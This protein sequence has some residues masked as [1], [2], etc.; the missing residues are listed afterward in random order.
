MKMHYEGGGGVR[1]DERALACVGGWRGGQMGG[2]AIVRENG[3]K[4]YGE[5]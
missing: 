3:G 1:D 4:G 2:G 5:R